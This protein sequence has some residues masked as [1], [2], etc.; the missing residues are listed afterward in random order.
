ML[1][2]QQ[3]QKRQP[4]WVAFSELWLDTELSCGDL[5]RI[6]RVMA[7]SGLSLEELRQIYLFEVAPVV[8]RNLLTVAGEWAAFDEKWLCSQIL[9]NLRDRPRLTRF[10]TRFP[11][12]RALMLYASERHW[13]RLV[14]L[15]QRFR[16][17]P[18]T[19]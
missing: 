7:D 2:E 10:W 12:T 8:S 6:A 3:I 18:S 1:D 9:R 4:L 19:S 13:R 5:E 14:E 17:N 15:V 11:L 16:D